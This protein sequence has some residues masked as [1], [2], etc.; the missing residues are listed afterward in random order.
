MITTQQKTRKSS[1]QYTVSSQKLRPKRTLKRTLKKPAA[2]PKQTPQKKSSQKQV[3][4]KQV[5]Q[6]Q[7]LQKQ[8]SKK[9]VLKKQSPQKQSSK[10][11][12]LQKQALKKQ[13]LQKK[14]K[15]S[16]KKPLSK[17]SAK[18]SLSTIPVLS[19][20]NLRK[21][22]T[23][24]NNKPSHILRGLNLVAYKGETIAIMGR[25]GSGKSTLISIITGLEK[26]DDGMVTIDEENIA[27]MEENELTAFRAKKIAIVFQQFHLISHLNALENVTLPL[28]L[29]GEKEGITERA[30]AALTQLG[31]A[32]VKAQLPSQLSG[33]EQ[34]RLAIA[35]SL[36]VKPSILLADEPTGNLDQETSQKV[37][38]Q[39]FDVVKKNNV[40]L[41]IATHDLELA[42][43]C[44]SRYFLEKGILRSF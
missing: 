38:A 32:H 6:K 19:V 12:S 4:Q 25:S 26:P 36:V 21:S 29:I 20:Q 30:E 39:L 1:Q 40:T 9:Q 34:Q 8:S 7:A 17:S 33:G 15:N 44:R 27:A 22:F 23:I 24:A 2:A 31:L 28:N 37:V 5:S 18:K 41:I 16:A 43:K 13:S 3:S 10:K 35:R 11:Q 42:K 14:Q